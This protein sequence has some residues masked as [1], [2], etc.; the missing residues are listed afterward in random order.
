MQKWISLVGEITE[1][2][3]GAVGITV[4]RNG[5]YVAFL[6]SDESFADLALRATHMDKAYYSLTHYVPEAA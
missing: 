4:Q 3:D 6:M 1:V 5:A 2:P